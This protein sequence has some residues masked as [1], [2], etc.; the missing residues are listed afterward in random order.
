MSTS[1]TCSVRHGLPLHHPG[2]PLHHVVQA[3]QVLNVHCGQYVDAGGEQ[4]L[5]VLPALGVPGAGRVGVRQLVDHHDLG[6]AG[7][8]GL[9][10]QLAERVIAVHVP[11]PGNA[12]Q[13][14]RQLRG[15]RPAVVL[16]QADHHIG[17]PVGTPVRLA[18]HG[19]RLAD[20]GRG[21]QV[22]PQLTAP[23]LRLGSGLRLSLLS[24]LFSLFPGPAFRL[25]LLHCE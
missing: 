9:G 23:G 18:E 22:D 25:Y 4:L 17:A 14:G 6:A 10:V 11:P 2:D 21:A 16:Y 8:H 15:P 5:D 13:P 7:Q 12:L 24:H 20:A 1:S 19:E 3:L